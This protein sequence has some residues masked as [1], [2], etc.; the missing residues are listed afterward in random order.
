M[1][2]FDDAA[3]RGSGG[4]RQAHRGIQRLDGRSFAIIQ[5]DQAGFRGSLRGLRGYGGNNGPLADGAACEKQ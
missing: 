3:E 2:L 1:I 5:S 4:R